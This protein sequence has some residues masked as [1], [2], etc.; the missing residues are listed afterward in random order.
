M[1]TVILLVGETCCGKDTIASMLEKDGYKVLKSYTTRPNRTKEKDTHI[2]IKPEDI[3]Q[4]KNNF[5]AYTKIGD[6]EYFSTK[7]QLFNSDIYIIDPNGIKYL[8]SKINNIKFVVIYINVD[9]KER[10]KRAEQIRKDN[11]K[12]IVKRFMAEKHQFD[13]FK[14]NA[15]FDYSVKNYDLEKSYRI[16]K[17]IILEEI[18]E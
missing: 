3:Y 13:E 10:L 8:K 7:Q 17:N 11:K 14:I 5:I 16:I 4:Y 6:Y 2:F 15:G 12:E 9:E 18:N 1:K